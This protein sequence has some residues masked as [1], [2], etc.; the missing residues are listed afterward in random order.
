MGNQ[1]VHALNGVDLDIAAGEYLAIMGASG[2]GKSTMM[3]L[4]GC[5]DTPTSG[6]YSLNDTKVEELSDE[7]LAK[8]RNREIG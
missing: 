5:L 2:S 8:I 7:Q 4:L 1:E 6:S 3:N